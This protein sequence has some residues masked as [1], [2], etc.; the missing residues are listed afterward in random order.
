M[1]HDAEHCNDENCDHDHS[2]DPRDELVTVRDLLRYAV[3]RFNR[4]RLV[5]GH[6][7]DNAFDE[8]AYLI[9]HTLHLPLDRLDPFL[10][11]CIPS[12]ERAEVLAVIDERAESRKPAAYLTG[13]AWLGPYRFTV[14]ERVIVPR[15]YFGELLQDGFAP[16]VPDPD[17]ITDALDLCTGSACLAIL[18]A[19][20]FPNANIDA[21]DLSAD[22]L[23][24]AARNVEDYG[25]E[26]QVHLLQS[27][28]FSALGGRCYDLI[29]SNPPYVTQDAM[30]AL[31]PEYLHEPAMALGSGTDGLDVVRK[32]IAQAHAH[33]KPG[34]LLAVEVG[35]NRH[36]VEEAWPD[37]QMTWLNTAGAD[38]GVFLIRREDLPA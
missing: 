6:G 28:V 5:F 31:P 19:H 18:M 23:E 33:L 26:H 27:D 21:V 36:L 30:D 4:A 32:I 12:N 14:D 1:H 37:L 11:A 3:S 22:A 38:E 20:V 7:T 2:H 13:E 35:H 29:I 9:L 34:G 10:D 17:E 15:S 25:L 16:W 24:V 8:A